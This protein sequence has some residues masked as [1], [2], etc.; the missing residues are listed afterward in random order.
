MDT[1][2]DEYSPPYVMAVSFSP[3]GRWLATSSSS[4]KVGAPHGYKAGLITIRDAKSGREL[5][6]F[7]DLSHASDS[8]A[9]S[10]DGKLFAAGTFGASGELTEP[11]ELRI[12]DTSD[13]ELLHVWKARDSLIPGEDQCSVAGI[14]F[15]PD[16]SSIALAISDGTVRLWD[17]TTRK[18]RAELKG[19]RG[20]VRRVAF[21]PNGRWLASAGLDRTVRVWDS[22]TGTQITL[23]DVKASKIN[24]LSFSPD[25]SLL[26]AGGGDFLRMGEV[27]MWRMKDFTLE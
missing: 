23:F 21:G 15:S 7:D 18:P 19:H 6:R 27:R 25:G 22:A 8:I 10:P 20:S 14:A 13:W 5:H 9:F 3:D 2:A 1:A 11:G 4:S 26:A 24:A 16:S 12:W 17:V